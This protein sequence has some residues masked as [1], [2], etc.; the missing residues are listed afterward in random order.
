MSATASP[1]LRIRHEAFYPGGSSLVGNAGSPE[2]ARLLSDPWDVVVLQVWQ[3]REQLRRHSGPSRTGCPIPPM[4][5]HARCVMGSTYCMARPCSSDAHWCLQSDAVTNPRASGPEPEPC[6]TQPGPVCGDA[7]RP[8]HVLCGLRTHAI[9]CARCVWRMK[10]MPVN[11]A[12]RLPLSAPPRP[13]SLSLPPP[14]PSSPLPLSPRREREAAACA[15][16]A[17][18]HRNRPV[19][20]ARRAH[21]RHLV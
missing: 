1:P 20:V 9:L 13:T 8:R 5:P 12:L 6:R 10:P 18:L 16:F 21:A 17:F 15:H 4:P 19:G 7:C 2:V 14:L 11:C 3:L